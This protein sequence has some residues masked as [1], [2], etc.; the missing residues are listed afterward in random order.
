M[1]AQAGSAWKHVATEGGCEEVE[2]YAGV[3]VCGGGVW[4]IGERGWMV[5]CG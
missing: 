1:E 4:D 5:A 2:V 3:W